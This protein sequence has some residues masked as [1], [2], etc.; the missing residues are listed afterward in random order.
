MSSLEN[1]AFGQIQNWRDHDEELVDQ[2]RT[3]LTTANPLP[4]ELTAGVF[5]AHLVAAATTTALRQ[6][7]N[8]PLLFQR[9]VDL[10]KAMNDKNPSFGP[11]LVRHPGN[12]VRDRFYIPFNQ[13]AE[14]VVITSKTRNERKRA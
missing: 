4:A 1:H 11:L 2:L 3:V 14:A 13:R 12:M 5:A 9:M 7:A 10:L 8:I 6:G